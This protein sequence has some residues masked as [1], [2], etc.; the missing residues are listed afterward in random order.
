MALDLQKTDFELGHKIHEHLIKKG[1][2]TPGVTVKS[3]F[4]FDTTSTGIKIDKIANNFKD[5][6]ITLGLDLKD[7]SLTETP[8]RVAKMLIEETMWGLNIDLF[9]KITTIENK[10]QYSEMVVERGI[11]V[12]S[13]CE[14]HFVQIDGQATVAYIPNK[15]VLGLSKMNRIVEYF[16][17]R[18]QV[19][20]RLGEQIYQALAYVLETENVAVL[21]DAEHYCVKSRG[22]QDENSR[23]VTSKLGGAFKEHTALRAEFMSIASIKNC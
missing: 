16:S 17:R 19:Q 23:T 7:D 11:K 8:R 1:I 3:V 4:N 10:M 15:K 22:I 13:L 2:E 6:M 20:E 18:P 9:P 14:H 12:H 21:I 5:I